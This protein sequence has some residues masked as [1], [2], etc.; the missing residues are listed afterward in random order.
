MF[1]YRDLH[2]ANAL[3]LIKINNAVRSLQK[4]L[5]IKVVRTHLLE[6]SNGSAPST[7]FDKLG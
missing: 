5:D 1:D 2:N 4:P 7:T 6:I 3:Q